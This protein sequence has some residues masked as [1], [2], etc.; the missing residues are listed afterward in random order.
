MGDCVGKPT[1]RDVESRTFTYVNE[2]DLRARRKG[3]NR[4]SEAQVMAGTYHCSDCSFAPH[5]IES[6]SRE[7]PD[8]SPPSI[9]KRGSYRFSIRK[10]QRFPAVVLAYSCKLELLGEAP[11]AVSAPAQRARPAEG[12]GCVVDVAEFGK[13]GRKFFNIGFALTLPALLPNLAG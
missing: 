9:A 13:A 1:L 10:A 12:I 7:R 2:I 6:F 11:L 4:P 5:S 3:R 8:S